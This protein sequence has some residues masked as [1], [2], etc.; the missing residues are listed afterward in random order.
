MA[1]DPK[2]A[3]WFRQVLGQYPTGVCVV[4]AT[5]E[6]GSRAGFVVGSF[7]SVSLDPPLVAFFPDK[8]STS[9]PKIA[10]AGSFCVNILGA[11][12]EHVCRRFASTAPDKFEGIA[13]RPAGSGAPIIEGVVAW[14]DCDLE[15]VEEAGDHF[16]VVGRVRE[17]DVESKL[18]PLLFFQGGYGRFAPL[19]LA[20]AN[21]GGTLTHQLRDVDLVRREMEMLAEEVSGRCVATARIDDELVVAASAGGANTSTAATLVGQRVPFAPPTGSAFSAWGG[22]DEVARWLGAAKSDTARQ[23]ARERLDAVRRRGYSVGLLNEA[24]RVFASTID[25]LASEPGSVTSEDLRE[26]IQ[27]LA[28][29]PVELSTQVKRNIRI[30]TAPVFGRDGKVALAFSLYG[31]PNPM[32]RG[33]IDT[34]IARVVEAARRATERLGGHVPMAAPELTQPPERSA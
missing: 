26:L 32:T 1:T 29:D 31:F 11:E 30:I 20:A 17:L 15:R 33:G 7:S 27:D 3:R 6:D 21:P 18:L 24:Q 2:D 4:T 34:Y 9:W 23:Y 25:R 16:F 14:I 13:C 8:G 22:A 19:S 5:Q 28:Y 12:Q 10:A